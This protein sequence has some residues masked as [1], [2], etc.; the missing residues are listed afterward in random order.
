MHA[1]KRGKKNA[2]GNAHPSQIA[3]IFRD[4]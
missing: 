4:L 2:G 3:L 1:F